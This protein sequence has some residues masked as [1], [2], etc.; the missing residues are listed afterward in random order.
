M[1]D[2]LNAE[3][4]ALSEDLADMAGQAAVAMRKATRAL[5]T[6]DFLLAEAVITADAELDTARN[7]CEDHAQRLLA[8]QS[9]VAGDLRT[10]MGALVCAV[11]IERM[12][13]LA[14]H[15]HDVDDRTVPAQR[16]ALDD[17]VDRMHIRKVLSVHRGAPAFGGQLVRRRALRR[18]G[19]VDEHIDRS[20]RLLDFVHDAA[21][22]GR[23]DQIARRLV[24]LVGRRHVLQLPFCSG[25]IHFAPRR[26]GDLRPLRQERFGTREADPL[27]ASGN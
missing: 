2:A 21:R 13:D 20:E 4:E 26:D 15:A 10:V 14:A 25:Q 6:C 3:L 18:A 16:H 7:T 11:K 24:D 22:V 1:R 5:T 12:G 9:P 17:G 19:A 8:L 27:A 23:V